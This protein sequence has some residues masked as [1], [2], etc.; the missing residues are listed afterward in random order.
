MLGEPTD[1][2]S[3]YP[4]TGDPIAISL[5]LTEASTWSPPDAVVV[6]GCEGSATSREC[7]CLHTNFAAAPGAARALLE[8]APSIMGEILPMPVAIERGRE[9][10][11]GLLEGDAQEVARADRHWP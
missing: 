10:F 5:E 4:G 7:T 8:A 1:V 2:S 11:S 3:T 9:N 6:A